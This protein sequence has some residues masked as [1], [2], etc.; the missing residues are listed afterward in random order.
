MV[1]PLVRSAGRKEIRESSVCMLHRWTRSCPR[2]GGALRAEISLHRFPACFAK[3]RLS[4]EL[5]T[6]IKVR[7]FPASTDANRANRAS[8]TRIAETRLGDLALA[9]DHSTSLVPIRATQRCRSVRSTRALWIRRRSRV[10][11]LLV[12]AIAVFG[13]GGAYGLDHHLGGHSARH[14]FSSGERRTIPIKRPVTPGWVRAGHRLPEN[15][16]KTQQDI[17]P[18]LLGFPGTSAAHPAMIRATRM[19]GCNASNRKYSSST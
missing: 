12:R 1:M 13:D 17:A 14:H 3:K 7:K 5:V 11:T 19:P 4:A 2:M 9:E 16:M 10:T 6:W 18:G 15:A 8:I